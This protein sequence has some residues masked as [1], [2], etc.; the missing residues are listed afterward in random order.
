MRI[1][2]KMKTWEEAQKQMRAWQNKGEK[3]VFT[4]GC[5][6]LL[7]KGHVLYLEAAKALGEKMVVAVNGDASVSRLKGPRRPIQNLEGRMT[8]LAALASVDLVVSF[9]EDTPLGL[10]EF[11]KPNILAKGGDWKIEDI[12][13]GK[14]VI[15]WGG[16]VHSIT[17]HDGFS[18]TRIVEKIKD[19][20][21]R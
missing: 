5:F 1:E 8:V 19:N 18:T 21:N 13:G 9:D 11:L 15:E 14:E 17:F 4:N 2:E 20:E 16:E 10:I 7:H 6:D 3:V 12:V